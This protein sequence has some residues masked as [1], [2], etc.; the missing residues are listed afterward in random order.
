MTTHRMCW[1]KGSSTWKL[2]GFWRKTESALRH[3]SRPDCEFFTWMGHAPTTQP[4]KQRRKWQRRGCRS[5]CLNHPRPF[6]SRSGG[7]HGRWAT[8]EDDHRLIHAEGQRSET[9]CRDSAGTRSRELRIRLSRTCP[10]KYYLKGV[11]LQI[12]ILDLFELILGHCSAVSGAPHLHCCI[13]SECRLLKMM[14]NLSS[15]RKNV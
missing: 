12:W 2:R 5:Q 10:R 8:D 4:R 6:W 3:P 1:R 14:Q 9:G 15:V 13:M 7:C 11:R